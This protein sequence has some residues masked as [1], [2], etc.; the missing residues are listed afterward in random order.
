M[1]VGAGLLVT[2]RHCLAVSAE[3]SIGNLVDRKHADRAWGN[4]RGGRDL[5]RRADKLNGCGT[6]I[7]DRP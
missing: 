3:S 4:G 5:R 1:N 2:A 6:F 7:D